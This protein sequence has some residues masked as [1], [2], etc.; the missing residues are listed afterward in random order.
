LSPS[1]HASNG[2]WDSSFDVRRQRADGRTG[3]S[4]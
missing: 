1:T 2:A 3:V 4:P